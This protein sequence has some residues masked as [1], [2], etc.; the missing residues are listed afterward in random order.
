MEPSSQTT[1]L[2]NQQR[3]LLKIQQATAK[4]H[5]I[6]TAATEAIAIIGIGCRFPDGVDNPEAYW[7]FLKD[8]RDVRTDIPKDRWDI[9]RYY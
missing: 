1:K 9:E 3:L 6:E 8:G 4:L 7:Q 2:S 5:E